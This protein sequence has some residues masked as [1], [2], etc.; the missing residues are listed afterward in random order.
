MR[1]INMEGTMTGRFRTDRPNV[2]NKPRGVPKHSVML[3]DHWPDED[4]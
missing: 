1:D 3:D 4:E 2:A